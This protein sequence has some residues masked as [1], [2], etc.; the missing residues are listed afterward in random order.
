MSSWKNDLI[1][2]DFNSFEIGNIWSSK[3][4]L[5]QIV[6][7]FIEE[8]GNISFDCIAGVETKGL[9][10]ASGLSA[11][12][13]MPL[14]VFRKKGKISYTDKKVSVNFIN[15]KGQD[16]GV[17]IEENLLLKYKNILIV[18]DLAYSLET[19]KS[20]SKIVQG[21]SNISVFLCIANLSKE[22][23]IKDKKIIS[24]MNNEEN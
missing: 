24:L 4:N 14:I 5:S 2:V 8:L 13:G 21:R 16:D 22:K 20:I 6:D 3:N 17:E 12:T 10:L 7:D 23:E 1:S 15:W 11:K 19:F 9:I 18:D